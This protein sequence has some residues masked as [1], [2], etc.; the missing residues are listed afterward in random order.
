[1]SLARLRYSLLNLATDTDGEL[2]ML[3]LPKKLALP[4]L[5]PPSEKAFFPSK[6]GI[7]QGVSGR[8]DG[9]TAP[10]FFFQTSS[11]TAIFDVLTVIRNLLPFSADFQQKA[12]YPG[13]LKLFKR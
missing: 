5:P 10:F 12:Q 11:S 3:L 8:E 2:K 9:K 4:S 1:M 13:R 7:F 6:I